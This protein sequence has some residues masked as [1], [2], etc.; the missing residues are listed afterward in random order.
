MLELTE[1]LKDTRQMANELN[2]QLEEAKAEAETLRKEKDQLQEERAEE[3]KI[4]KE[5]LELALK[6]RSQ[7]EAKWKNDFEQLRTHHSDREEHLMED[8]EWKLRSMQKNCKEKL[9]AVERERKAAV[10]KAARLEQEN[11]NNM[12]EVSAI[13][14]VR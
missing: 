11:R 9:E 3:Q 12:A 10:D 6:E 1:K 5:A 7:V 14:G 8:C 13:E 2:A 4:I